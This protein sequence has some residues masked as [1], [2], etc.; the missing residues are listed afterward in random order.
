MANIIL[1][2]RC[3][4][5][6]K[7]GKL[8][9]IKR[10]EGDSHNTGLWEFPG[11]KL[12]EG[13]DLCRAREDEIYQE[14]KLV[15]DIIYSDVFIKSYVIDKGKYKGVAYVAIFSIG[16]TL[17]DRV[18][19]SSEHDDYVWV[20]YEDAFEYDLTMEVKQALITLKKYLK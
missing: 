9:I 18:V 17:D 15:F 16:K 5:L 2:T 6:N 14:T 20:E 1:V 4:I 7:K 11:G 8:L 19:L 12:E 3:L 10:A 13:Q